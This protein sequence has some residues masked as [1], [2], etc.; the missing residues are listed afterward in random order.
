MAVVTGT[1]RKLRSRSGESGQASVELV[2][3]VPFALLAGLVAWQL[4]LAGHAAWM[5]ANAARA[6]ARAETVGKDGEAAARSALPRG[7]ERGAKVARGDDGEVTVRVRVPS[8]LP[9]FDSTATV[10]ASAALG[11]AP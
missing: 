1:A 10:S 8:A 7:L 11:Q 3:V 5:S 9:A 4:V 2:A 6:G